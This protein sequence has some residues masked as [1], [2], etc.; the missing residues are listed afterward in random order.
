[1][2]FF[3]ALF[4]I[5]ILGSLKIKRSVDMVDQFKES[6]EIKQTTRLIEKYFGGANPLNILVDGDLQ[7][8]WVLKEMLRA[9]KFIEAKHLV[10]NPISV[11]NLIAEMNDI[12][13]D[14]KIVPD[15]KAKIGN[16]WFLIEGQDILTSISNTEKK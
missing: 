10:K 5:G 4:I 6:S 2:V 9:Q 11:G 15:D 16:L 14:E 7:N 1:M 12:M 3:S 13:V 8:P